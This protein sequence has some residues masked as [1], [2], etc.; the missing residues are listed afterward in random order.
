MPISCPCDVA[1]LRT[2]KKKISSS[3]RSAVS[4]YGD[5]VSYKH[6]WYNVIMLV[7]QGECTVHRRGRFFCF[8]CLVFP[9]ILISILKYSA[10]WGYLLIPKILSVCLSVLIF[11]PMHCIV[12]I[13][14]VPKVREKAIFVST[15]PPTCIKSIFWVF[16]CIFLPFCVVLLKGLRCAHPPCGLRES[17]RVCL[18]C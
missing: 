2:S 10:F 1:H 14:R 15:W 16:F 17:E 18:H 12:Q 8:L 4:D 11:W 9:Q 13:S 5:F 3:S 6:V 7:C